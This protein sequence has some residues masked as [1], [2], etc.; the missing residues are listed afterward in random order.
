MPS[1]ISAPSTKLIARPMPSFVPPSAS[2][3]PPPGS[4]CSW[5]A[6]MKP[7]ATKSAVPMPICTARREK[8]ETMPAPSHAPAT[9]AAISSTSVV[10]STVTMAM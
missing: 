7:A 10:K 6:S 2:A 1:V 3:V 8:P 9:A 5:L 4:S